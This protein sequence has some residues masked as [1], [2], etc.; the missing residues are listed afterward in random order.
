MTARA[1]GGGK[2]RRERREEGER[3]GERDGPSRPSNKFVL[4]QGVSSSEGFE[5]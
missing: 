3:R 4:P 5:D 2:K 1:G